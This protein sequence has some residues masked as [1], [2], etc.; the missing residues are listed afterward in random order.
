MRLCHVG[1]RYLL[2]RR[3]E[4][5]VGGL[6]EP[7]TVESE[8]KLLEK[9]G[10]E[11]IVSGILKSLPHGMGGSNLGTQRVTRGGLGIKSVGVPLSREV[12]RF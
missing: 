8:E 1:S 7:M 5:I 3:K 2:R 10:W 9:A 12:S 4:P 11:E 6:R